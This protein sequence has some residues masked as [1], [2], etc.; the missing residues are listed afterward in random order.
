MQRVS[1]IPRRSWDLAGP[2]SKYFAQCSWGGWEVGAFSI[3]SGAMEHQ[4]QHGSCRRVGFGC[5]S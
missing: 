1:C 4:E 5:A 3:R 2:Q